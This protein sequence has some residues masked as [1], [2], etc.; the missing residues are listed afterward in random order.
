MVAL[1]RPRDVGRARFTRL[2]KGDF[3]SV[4]YRSLSERPNR[5]F[6]GFVRRLSHHGIYVTSD[7]NLNQRDNV[8][9][10]ILKRSKDYIPF[11]R[12]LEYRLSIKNNTRDRLFKG[13]L[14]CDQ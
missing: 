13:A 7:L 8:G 9:R 11:N 1:N 6:N 14:S 5:K 2:K 12:I 4:R 10:P 3:I